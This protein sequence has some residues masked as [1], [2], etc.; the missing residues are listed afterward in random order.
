MNVYIVVEGNMTETKIYPLWLSLLAPK[1]Q[2]VDNLDNI[3]ENHYYLFSGGGIP[4]I[5]SHVSNAVADIC[6]FNSK[7][8]EKIDYLLVC[9]DTEEESREYIHE[10]IDCQLK[11]DNRKIID[12]ELKIFEQKVCMET[13]LLGN[14]AIFKSNPQ[15]PDYLKFIQYYNVGNQNPE[16]MGNFDNSRYATKAQFHEAYLK[17]MF[18][19]RRMRYSKSN[20]Q[21][22]GEQ[23][24]L[25]KLIDRYARTGQIATFGS[26][27]EFVKNVLATD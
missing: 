18:Q 21:Y 17:K 13:W 19:E 4:S 9:L 5:Y 27:Y 16:D 3:V 26:W 25:E 23:A 12:F 1:L 7:K 8:K 15:D 2:R 22:V 10:R 24:Y 11:K 14:T 6:Q 20:P